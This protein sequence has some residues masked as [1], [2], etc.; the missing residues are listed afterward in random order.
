MARTVEQIESFFATVLAVSAHRAFGLKLLRW[1][2]GQAELFFDPAAAGLG[3]KGEVHGGVLSLLLEPAA[4]FALFPLL[5]SDRYA[6]TVDAHVQ[7]MK[8]ADPNVRIALVGSTLRLGR[9]LA[10]CEASAIQG[11]NVCA[12]ARFTKAVVPSA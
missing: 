1:Q 6:V 5:P 7:F 3:P 11:E 2:P 9:Q 4:A 10:F 8:A 12:L